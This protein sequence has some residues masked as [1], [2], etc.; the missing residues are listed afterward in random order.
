MMRLSTPRRERLRDVLPGA[1]LI[2]VMWQLLQ[3]LG[4][5]YV[6]HVIKKTNEMNGVFALVLGLIA[7]IYIA[8]VLAMLG[9][10]VNVVLIKRLYPRAPPDTVHRCGPAH[11]SRQEGVP[12]VRAGATAQGVRGG[13]GQ[14][15]GGWGGP[16]SV[17]DRGP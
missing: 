2:A 16:T 12:G 3:L 11:R 14:L 15:R 8:T 5:V 6:E 10:E 4:G 7:L 17:Y 9:I 1:V 13:A